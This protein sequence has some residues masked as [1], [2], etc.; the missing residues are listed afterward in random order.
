LTVNE[1]VVYVFTTNCSLGLIDAAFKRPGRID[2][3]MQFNPPDAE[4]RRKLIERWHPEILASVAMNE[5]V[6]STREHSFA[7]IEELKNL[8]I[9]NFMECGRWDWSWALRQ[10]AINRREL[11]ARRHRRVGFGRTV[12]SMGQGSDAE[13]N[14]DQA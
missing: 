3:V 9:M 14:G 8:L 7:E 6:A 1:G 13:R 2:L 4:L 12:M 11:N 10:F 5:M